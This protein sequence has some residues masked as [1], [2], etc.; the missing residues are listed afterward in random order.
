MSKSIIMWLGCT[1][2]ARFLRSF[3]YKKKGLKFNC[4]HKNNMEDSLNM[5]ESE[6]MDVEGEGEVS[7]NIEFHLFAPLIIFP[8]K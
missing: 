7:R 4:L 5:E 1:Y 2:F 8:M 6:A 3:P